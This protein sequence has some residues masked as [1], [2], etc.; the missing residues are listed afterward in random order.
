MFSKGTQVR[1]AKFSF[2]KAGNNVMNRREA[3]Y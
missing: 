1:R 2:F 3:S